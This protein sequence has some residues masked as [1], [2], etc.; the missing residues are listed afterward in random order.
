MKEG[1]GNGCF[2]HIVFFGG[3]RTNERAGR[4]LLLYDTKIDRYVWLVCY[5]KGGMIDMM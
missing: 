4:D 1:N 2:I 3:D 5:N